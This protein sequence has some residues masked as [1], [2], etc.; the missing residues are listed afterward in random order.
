MKQLKL[1][2]QSIIL[3]SDRATLLA[4]KVILTCSIIII[5]CEIYVLQKL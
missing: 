2:G 4:V 3:K 5:A 1:I